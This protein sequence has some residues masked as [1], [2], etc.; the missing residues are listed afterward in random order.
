MP[1]P[2]FLDVQLQAFERLLQT[3]DGSGEVRD[4]GLEL[5]F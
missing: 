3:D 5:Y 2:H 4:V 1:M